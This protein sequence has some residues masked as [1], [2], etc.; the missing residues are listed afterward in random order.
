MCPLIYPQDFY[1]LETLGTAMISGE[2]AID[3]VALD[4]DG[5]FD[6]ML[7]KGYCADLSSSQVLMDF[8]QGLYPAVQKEI[9]KD[10]K[11]YAIP[12]SI[13]SSVL[14][15]NVD[16]LE[17]VGLTQEDVPTNLVDL[18]AF[19]TRW[20]NEWM[21]DENKANVM[22]ICTLS[23]NR[24]IVFDMMLNG[25]I[26][27]YDATGQTLDFDTPLFNQLLTALDNMVADN[28]DRP[29]V[30]SDMEYDEFYQLYSGLFLE[31]SLLSSV[32][33]GREYLL[34]PLA[35]NNELDYQGWRLHAGDVCQ[36]QLCEHA[37]SPEAAGML[38]AKYQPLFPDTAFAEC[39][40]S[41]A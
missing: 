30:M 9:M 33:T 5:G 17:E 24:Q 6:A 12:V 39:Q 8:V 37:G 16:K 41:P 34:G 27:Y 40:R 31:D 19:I 28:L 18:C 26:D 36:S 13:S 20:N 23:S 32:S 25:Y 38:C 15:Y 22:P 35:L 11:L 29:A 4:V 14:C 10:G 7:E 1:S 2:T 3:L 21:D